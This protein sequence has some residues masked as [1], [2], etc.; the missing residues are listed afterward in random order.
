MAKEYYKVT[1]PN[2]DDV[3]LYISA[4]WYTERGAR[5]LAEETLDVRPLVLTY[6]CEDEEG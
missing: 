6:V 5:N 1:T 4:K 3:L 2:Q